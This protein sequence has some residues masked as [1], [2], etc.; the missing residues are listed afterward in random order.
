MPDSLD[1]AEAFSAKYGLKF[2]IL[3][4][5]MA[6][7]C[8]VSLSIAVANAGSMGALG[9]LMSQ[10]AA[11]RGWVSEFRSKSNGPLQLNIWIPDPP[12]RRDPEAEERMKAFL[13]K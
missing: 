2:P 3:L 4:A 10:P 11:I 7:S 12:P 5:P 6:G 1:R 9:A 13:S 8:P